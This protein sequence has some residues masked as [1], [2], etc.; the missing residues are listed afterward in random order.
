MV[1][2]GH[3]NRAKQA[4]ETVRHDIHAILRDG[5]RSSV[6]RLRLSFSVWD[7]ECGRRRRNFRPV[8]CVGSR[9]ADEH[10]R[11]HC[12][13]QPIVSRT[14]TNTSKQPY[15]TSVARETDRQCGYI[16]RCWLAT[17]PADYW[18]RVTAELFHTDRASHH[19]GS[20]VYTRDIRDTY[21]SS[22]VF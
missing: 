15:F 9:E 6:R 8:Q 5:V 1:G 2:C 12:F 14:I 3:N 7:A 21:V 13:S 20:A 4:Y 22:V 11:A 16:R 10:L 19:I 17:R 18:R